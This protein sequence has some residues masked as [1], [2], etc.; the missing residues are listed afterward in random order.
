[1]AHQAPAEF[2][3]TFGEQ[4]LRLLDRA[5][6]A[7]TELDAARQR[8]LSE[9]FGDVIS[10]VGAGGQYRLVFR[11]GNALAADALSLPSGIVILTDELVALS[12]NNDELAAVLAHEIGHA[13]HRHTLRATLQNSAMASLMIAAT[14]DIASAANLAASVPLLLAERS[15]SR[16]FERE[17]DD[18]AFE[19]LAAKG[20]ERQS[21]AELLLR[22]ESQQGADDAP[23]L[24]RTHP[25]AQDRVR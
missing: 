23:G 6:L 2:E 20:I 11:R 1:M 25:R 24:L 18:V 13:L 22:I 5:I 4:S 8:E 15:Y 17:A 19:Y 9:L 10:V 3:I 14:G 7:P 12:T 21:L 16:A